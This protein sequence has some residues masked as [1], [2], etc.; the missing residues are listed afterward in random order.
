MKDDAVNRAPAHRGAG[1]LAIWGFLA[2]GGFQATV[3][4]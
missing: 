3:R 4:I 2:G 1:A